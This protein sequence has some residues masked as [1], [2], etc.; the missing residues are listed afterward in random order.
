M[1]VFLNER[2]HI[3]GEEWI[4]AEE[5]EFRENISTLL[6][7]LNCF[8]FL[9]ECNVFY[10][11]TGMA[12]LIDNVELISDD[13][14]LHNEVD[15]LRTIIN[16]ID[17]VDWD[18]NK[19]QAVSEYNYLLQLNGGALVY[20][21]NDTTLAEAAEYK[22]RNNNVAILNLCSSEFNV[23]ATVYVNRSKVVPPSEMKLLSLST[24]KKEDEM[25]D[26]FLTNREVINFNLNKKHGENH[27]LVKT[28]HGEI[29]SPLKCT[30]EEAQQ[31]LQK[32]VGGSSKLKE[33][34]AYD[35]KRGCYIVF[36]YDN[37]I[38][39]TYHGYHPH[40]QNEVVDDVKKFIANY[41]HLLTNE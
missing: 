15:Q 17:A 13:Y 35:K 20:N 14:I 22:N 10:S 34:Y 8:N 1:K 31:I 6:K 11:G 38:P 37:T 7:I 36:K 40:N 2:F 3:S 32:S 16:E 24:V 23:E 26:Y 41:L 29:I 9:K 18:N 5:T 21:V 30:A 33:L 25:I 12:A 4:P 27:S 19:I 28:I 39:K